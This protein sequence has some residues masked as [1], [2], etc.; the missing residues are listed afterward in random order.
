MS[1]PRVLIL[2]GGFGGLSC[3]LALSG[4]VFDVTV[5]DAKPSIEFLPAIHELISKRKTKAALRLPLKRILETAGHRFQRTRVLAIDTAKHRVTT[6]RGTRDY[7]LLVVALG[8]EDADFGVNGV[9]KHTMGF[10]SVDQCGA[11]GKQLAKLTTGRTPVRVTIIG[12]GLEG[13]EATGEL[14]RKYRTQQVELSLVEAAEK[15]L[16]ASPP[17]AGSH[18]VELCEQHGV[19][20]R[21]G[22]PVARVTPRTVKLADG[23]RL[24]SDLTI[25]TGGAVAPELYQ[26]ANLLH[27]CPWI[28]CEPTLRHSYHDS[29][30]VVGDA[31][32]LS[33]GVAKQAYH[34]M[35]MGVHC[36]QNLQRH[37]CG[38]RLRAFK[39]SAKPQLVAF[40]DIDTLL[41]HDAFGLASPSLAVLKEGIYQLVM[42]QLDQRRPVSRVKG[43]V[44]RG[45]G[46]ARVGGWPTIAP[47][48]LRALAR[49]QRLY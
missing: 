14:L 33:K 25:W 41:L 23:S 18:L 39:P 6:E 42:A 21:L 40:G 19:R 32:G 36:A 46:S 20:L 10:K 35:D 15:L 8:A 4:D 7:D 49:V 48:T 47:S 22:S 5:L 2:G 28:P 17:E 31:T 45:I 43:L 30:F 27:A 37:W 9:A 3:A 12:G 38:R 34:A 11:I 44:A 13:I 16:P 26:A 1:R 29:V 24:R